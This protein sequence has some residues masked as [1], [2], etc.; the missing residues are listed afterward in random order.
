VVSEASLVRCGEHFVP[1]I[2]VGDDV[3]A[4]RMMDDEDGPDIARWFYEG[5]FARK[6]LDLNDIAYALDGAV[7]KLRE[8]RVP[9]SR[10]AAF[11]H[12]G[13]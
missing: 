3:N 2:S 1:H 9:P 10:W 7:T 12:I 8:S 6:T 13:G 4:C 5:L 11:I